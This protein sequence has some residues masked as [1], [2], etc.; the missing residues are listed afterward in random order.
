MI[1]NKPTKKPCAVLGKLKLLVKYCFFK[2]SI[3]DKS[4]Q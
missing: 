3:T 2:K 1:A 4:N